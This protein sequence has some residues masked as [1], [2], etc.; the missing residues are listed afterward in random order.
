M[1][2]HRGFELQGLPLHSGRKTLKDSVKPEV[3]EAP[4]CI[5]ERRGVVLGGGAQGGDGDAGLVQLIGV[6]DIP[7]FKARGCN[8][9]VELQSQGEVF[10]GKVE[11]KKGLQPG[12]TV[13]VE[14]A[15]GTPDGAQ[16]Q[17]P[18]AK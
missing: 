1:V 5:F 7:T 3:E 15:F 2:G 9:G 12:E 18:G 13:V 6:A 4:R 16:V 10:D 14:G 8:L 11:I 17:L